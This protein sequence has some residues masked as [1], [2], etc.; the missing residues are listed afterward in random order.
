MALISSDFD[1]LFIVNTFAGDAQQRSCFIASS[2]LL[3]LQ[4]MMNLCNDMIEQ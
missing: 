2:Q 1:K 3:D 4:G